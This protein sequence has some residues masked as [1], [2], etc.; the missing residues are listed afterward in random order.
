LIDKDVILAKA[1]KV[2]HHL[3]RIKEKRKISLD[4]FLA[5]LYFQESILFNLQMALLKLY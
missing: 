5:D 3:R 2:E 1:Y 4:K